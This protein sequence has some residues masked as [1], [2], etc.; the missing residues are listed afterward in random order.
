MYNKNKTTLVAYPAGKT[1][2]TFTI[3]SS[4]TSI[5]NYAFRSCT[6]LASVTIPDGVTSIEYETFSGCT[7][8]T[9]III[10]NSVTS[11]GQSSFQSCR[12]LISIRFERANT[13]ITNN[14]SFASFIDQAN[15]TSLQSAY[16]AGG[17]GTYTRP[18]TSST[19]W[20]KTSN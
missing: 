3:L 12:S 7:S 14:S 8:L 18:D 20:T 9:S 4:V 16:I 13:S 19:M 10:P 2:S 6:S 11:I 15:T 1:D 17:I 5:G